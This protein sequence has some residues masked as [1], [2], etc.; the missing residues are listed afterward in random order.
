MK[1]VF[2]GLAGAAFVAGFFYKN[3]GYEPVT[4]P[5][6]I[7]QPLN[8][9]DFIKPIDPALIGYEESGQIEIKLQSLHALAVGLDDKLYVSG[10]LELLVFAPDGH[11]ISR[12]SYEKPVECI[13]IAPD[14]RVYLGLRDQVL[15]L[16]GE[17]RI[18]KSWENPGWNSHF[19]S[20]AST[21]SDVFVADAGNRLVWRYNHEGEMLNVI[22][23]RDMASGRIG[24]VIPGPFFDIAIGYE[25]NLWAVNPGRHA[26]ENYSVDGELRSSWQRVS[27]D[28][29]GFCGCCNPTHI[30]ILQDGGF[31]T[32][33]KGIPRVKIHE[34]SGDLR[35]VVAGP[36][37]FA[38][39]T[40]IADI[41]IDSRERILV[42]DEKAKA[43]RFFQKKPEFLSSKLNRKQSYE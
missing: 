32:C 20:I 8:L 16:N 36:K 17:N 10:D 9:D 27:I 1:F 38:E 41:A 19:T 15:V 33:E 7:V 40:V 14:N 13:N 4:G 5:E 21:E 37:S 12:S 39:G 34:P 31:V 18:I 22:G 29:D 2:I 6:K 26:L 23:E 24:F 42:L 43:V 30:A 3:R 11:E 25:G 35:T 28:I